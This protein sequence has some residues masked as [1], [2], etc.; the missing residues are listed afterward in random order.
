MGFFRPPRVVPRLSLPLRDGV[1]LRACAS[2]YDPA[3]LA[4]SRR[5]LQTHPFQLQLEVGRH[6]TALYCL[7]NTDAQIA[8][9][10]WVEVSTWPVISGNSDAAMPTKWMVEEPSWRP[11][12]KK[13]IRRDHFGCAD[14]CIVA[15]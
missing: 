14:G 6:S 9:S 4:D 13:A 12:P 3:P 11:L 10:Y 8:V 5:I 15:D 7:H 1:G 2:A